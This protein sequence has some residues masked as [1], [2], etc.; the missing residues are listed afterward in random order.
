MDQWLRDH[1]VCPRDKKSLTETASTLEC[2][3][4]HTYPVVAGVPIMLLDDVAP[5]HNAIPKTL[6]E[7]RAGSTGDDETV[8]GEDAIDPVVQAIVAAT[9]GYLY[10]PLVGKLTRYP[11]PDIPLERGEGKR[12]LDIGCNWGR[13]TI[14]AA[15]KGYV[16]VGI[17]PD[18][19]PVLAAQR[20]AAAEG[21]QASFVVGDA[22]FLPFTEES[23]DVVF[24]YSVI[25]HFSKADARTAIREVRRVLRRSGLSL[26]QMPNA[27]GIRS[28]YH[29]LRR[30][31]REGKEF[32]VRYWTPGELMRAFR[33]DVG[34]TTMEIDGFFGLGIQPA[35][36]DML[37]LRMKLIVMASETTRK[38]ASVVRPMMTFADSLYL[39]S[40]RSA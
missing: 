30:G 9:S 35:D 31:F 22:R 8:V 18:L 15:R 4:G 34:A 5:T 37:P 23:F 11:I 40:R 3:E 19:G 25:Q 26:I 17:D 21:V 33:E 10:K 20:V 2:R 38:V 24:S 27:L 36:I 28:L 14:A 13:W 1:L 32:D 6:A 39:L 7:V 29:Q 16:P 12:L